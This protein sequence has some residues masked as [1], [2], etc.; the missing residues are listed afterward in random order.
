MSRYKH[1]DDELCAADINEAA[2][3]PELDV[4][5]PH[6]LEFK[7]QLRNYSSNTINS[8]KKLNF[9]YLKIYLARR[10]RLER[11]LIF[12]ILLLLFLIFLTSLTIFYH[13][14]DIKHPEEICLT[15]AC[16]QVSSSIYSGMNQTINPC[17]DFYEF[18]CGRWIKTNII[19]KGHSGW[20]TTKELSRKNLIILKSILEETVTNNS[21]SV[22]NAEQEAIK[23]YQSCMNISE[24]ERRQIQPLE[25]FLKEN[26]NLTIHQ[27]IDIDQNQTWQDL[28]VLLTKILSKKYG[29]SYLLPISVGPDDKNS[30]WNVLHV[31][32]THLRVYFFYLL[33]LHN[34]KVNQPQ[35]GL[36]SRDYYINSSLNNRSDP[37]TDARN[38]IVNQKKQNFFSYTI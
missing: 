23:F 25:Q 2:V 22:F 9:N 37:D 27:W 14:H 24:I 31:S 11:S 12:T 10:T 33:L 16:I 32:I 17:E 20:S 6:Q 15:P 34:Q 26:F 5:E 1:F 19:P 21:V 30:T 13:Q 29:F 4:D 18:T 35:L 3:L 7:P 38:K 36:D 28:F 8:T